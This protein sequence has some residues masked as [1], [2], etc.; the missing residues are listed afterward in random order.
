MSATPDLVPR[1]MGAMLPLVPLLLIALALKSNDALTVPQFWAEDAAVFFKEQ[2]GK[3]WPQLFVPYAGYLLLVPRLVA[4]LA[5]MTSA[6]MAPLIYNMLAVILASASIA[7]TASKL[8]HIVPIPLVLASFLLVPTNGEVFGTITNVQWFLQFVLAIGCFTSSVDT[9]GWRPWARASVMFALALTGPFSIIVAFTVA[10]MLLA[11]WADRASGAGLFEG[12]LATWGRGRDLHAIAATIAGAVIQGSV[13]IENLA[14]PTTA[15]PGLWSALSICF[16]DLVPIHIFGF[17][18]LPGVVWIAIYACL[19]A[20]LVVG[21]R[22][23]GE[24][25]LLVLAMLAFA[26]TEAF[27]PMGLKDFI[28]MYQFNY[29][30]RYFYLIKVVFWWAAYAAL[31]ASVKVKARK[32]SVGVFVGIAAVALLNPFRMERREFIDFLWPEHAKQFAKPGLHVV[33]VN[34][35]GWTI[36]IDTPAKGTSP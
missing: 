28:G 16:L 4:W 1:K 35:Y 23:R 21:K 26:I 30:D 3:A 7:F 32:V 36:T 6:V 22:I 20:G 14:P 12:Q 18:L 5:S 19:L 31:A 29:G 8:R 2:Y 11:S 9:R 10:S 17:A 25:R 15:H 24:H 33:P 34:P 13:I 27:S